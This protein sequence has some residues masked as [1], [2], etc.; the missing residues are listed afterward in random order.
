M[1]V[2]VEPQPNCLVTLRVELPAD[3]V[4][5]EWQAITREFQQQ[6][7][8]PGY[9]P[10][11]APQSLIETR[12]AGDI[13]QE[14]TNKLVRQGLDEAIREKKL[15][16]IS[17]SDVQDVEVASGRAMRFRATVVTAPEFELPDYSTIPATIEKEV[18]TDEK[19]NQWMDQLREPHATYTP[20]ENRPLAMGD[21]AVL[22]YD[23]NLD[24]RPLAETVPGAPQQ[25]QGRR[26][27]W[28]RLAEG[29]LLPGFSEAIAGMNVN[30]TR[31]FSLELPAAFPISELA[32]KTIDYTTTL[33]AIN[34]KVFPDWDDALAEK[35]EPGSTAVT[36]REKVVGRL[37]E[38]ADR[39]FENARRQAAVNHLLA[40]VT[41][42]L[43][44]AVVE[45]EMS[46]ILRDIVQE[47]QVRGV[48][49]EEIRKHQEQLVG[50]AQQSAQERVRSNFILLR[51]AEKEG[52]KASEQDITMRVYELAA[53]Y[54]IP[55]NKLVKDLQRRD[56]FGPLREQILIGKALDLLGAN[57]TLQ[58]S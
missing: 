48:S 19:I 43:P 3:R 50:A 41:C 21:Y 18:V 25:I 51:I 11:K 34:S 9:R 14:L 23:G 45:R 33:H 32:G 28:V 31:A 58:S 40:H 26:N 55:V 10:G 22:T 36:L 46:G 16:V 13:K 6:A 35:I 47:N 57:V 2:V 54:E 15:R 5:E 53:R 39:Q 52:L 7:R 42:D 27:A 29:A 1:N 8:I 37:Q 38:M 17:V 49:D 44:A 56:G 12:Y 20:V 30:E 4:T 24:G